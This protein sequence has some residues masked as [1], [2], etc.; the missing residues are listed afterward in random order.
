MKKLCT[1]VALLICLSMLPLV[2]FAETITLVDNSNVLC[3]VEGYSTD[4]MGNFTI[5]L[6]LENK[7]DKT[8]MY[9]IDNGCI[10]GY[11]DDPFWAKELMPSSR[12]Y[13]E[14]TWFDMSFTP[15]LIEFRFRAYDSDD[16]FAD[17]FC[18]EQIVLYPLGKEN[19]KL[20]TFTADADDI[21]LVDT[22]DV[23]MVVTGYEPN[24]FMGYSMSVHLENRT[25]KE[26]MFSAEGATINGFSID[27][28]WAASIPAGRCY[29]TE[30]TWFSS[31]LEENGITDVR[32]I[33]LYMKVYDSNDWFSDDIINAHYTITP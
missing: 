27:P 17:D 9:S 11:V 5:K 21:V 29:D 16:W 31:D 33:V 3:R 10:D 7:T 19:V 6:Y 18:N 15:T 2:S 4:W 20:R 25:G 28:F 32:Q 12:S 14:V 1:L 26:L 23:M 8:V 30:I 22:P 24:G 13:A